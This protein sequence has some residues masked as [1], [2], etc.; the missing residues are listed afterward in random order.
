MQAVWG[1]A[2]LGT[3]DTTNGNPGQSMA[4]PG[5]A[6]NTVSVPVQ[7]A[8]ASNP[9]VYTADIYDDGLSANKRFTAGLRSTTVAN[10]IEMGM[11]NGPSHYAVRA[12]LPGPSWVAFSSITD[13]GGTPIQNAPIE[14]W[15]RFKVVLDGSTATFTL[16]LGSTGIINATEVLAA[17]WHPDGVNQVR[18]GGPSSLSS[19]GGGGNFDNVSLASVP[20]PATG[21]LALLALAPMAVRRRS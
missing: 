17:A 21:I 2:G 4:H 18:L 3:L 6:D 9:L 15:H 20:E 14:G 13:D 10:L 11:Y 5:G 19:A 7:Q 8:T 1:A 12:V 16:D